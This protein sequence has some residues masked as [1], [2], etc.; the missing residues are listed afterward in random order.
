MFIQKCL[1]GIPDQNKSSRYLDAVFTPDYIFD[2]CF[3]A[4]WLFQCFSNH[5]INHGR[6]ALLDSSRI[7]VASFFI[8]CKNKQQ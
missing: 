8:S 1:P 6:I 2:L 3:F 5:G 4:K 7:F